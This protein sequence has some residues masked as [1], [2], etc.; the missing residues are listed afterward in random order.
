MTLVREYFEGGLVCSPFP[1]WQGGRL[2]VLGLTGNIASGK[3]AV[4]EI[5]AG[6]GAQGHRRRPARARTLSSRHAYVSGHSRPVR[7]EGR[8]ARRNRPRRRRQRGVRRRS[9][10]GRPRGH[11]SSGRRGRDSKTVQTTEQCSG[12]G[13]RSNQARG[14][15]NGRPGRRAM[16]RNRIPGR[17]FETA[18]GFSRSRFWRGYKARGFSVVHRGEGS[19]IQKAAAGSAGSAGLTTTA[20]STG[21]AMRCLTPGERLSDRTAASREIVSRRPG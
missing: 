11:R 13:D 2:R 21:L 14:K 17:A 7:R 5:L 20:T 12:D 9:R 15:R 16:D 3:S 1:T 19:F 18:C 8:R 6:F 10:H 4:A